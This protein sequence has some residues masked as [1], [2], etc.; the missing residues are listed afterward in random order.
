MWRRWLRCGTACAVTILAGAAAD[1]EPIQVVYKVDVFRQCQFLEVESCRAFNASF[2]MTLTFD[3][4]VISEHAEEGR[5]SRSYGEPTVS[6]IPLPRRNDFPPFGPPLRIAAETARL[7]NGTWLRDSLMTIRHN[8]SVDRNDF[9]RDVSLI[10]DGG[11]GAM[12][13]LDARSFAR[14]LGTAPSRQFSVG[15]STELATGGFE[16]LVYY[17]RASLQEPVVTPEPASLFLVATGM[18]CLHR[19]RGASCNSNRQCDALTLLNS[20]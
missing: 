3:S 16:L 19:R 5:L 2:P 18:V 20:L 6:D 12:P 11:S 10:A 9:H 4:Q 1:A 8:V 7:E 14:F 15:D 13:E 17:G